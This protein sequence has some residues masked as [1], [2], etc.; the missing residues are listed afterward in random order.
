MDQ[1]VVV[2]VI[3]DGILRNGMR[4]HI[5]QQAHEPDVEVFPTLKAF[6]RA[7]MCLVDV[8][9]LDERCVMSEQVID[10]IQQLAEAGH[11]VVL[12]SRRLQAEYIRQ[13]IQAGARGCIYRDDQ[14][15]DSVPMAIRVVRRDVVYISPK[16]TEV[17]TSGSL[18]WNNLSPRARHVLKMMAQGMTVKEIARDLKV[19]P[20]TIYR[21]RERL[22]EALNVGTNEQ[23]VAEA[24]RQGLL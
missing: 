21:D 23:I 17:M 4:S 7:D 19:T 13:V 2:L 10:I 14:L 8:L 24:L 3:T 1:G 16:A 9:F 5:V 15:E 22:R 11:P 12:L 6:E 20:K 18:V